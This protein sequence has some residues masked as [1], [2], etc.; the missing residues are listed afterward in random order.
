MIDIFNECAEAQSTISITKGNIVNIPL[1]ESSDIAGKYY[2]DSRDVMLA[3]ENTFSADP[4]L[5]LDSIAEHNNVP[6]SNIIV[7]MRESDSFMES[8]F[9]DSKIM[10]EASPE[11][12]AMSI[13]QAMAWYKK[14]LKRS[15]GAGTKEELKERISVLK[16]CV[17]DMEK[18][19]RTLKR[20]GGATYGNKKQ[21]VYM[22]K[23][24]IPFNSIYRLIRRQDI[25]AGIGMLVGGLTNVLLPGLG[26]AANVTVRMTQYRNMIQDNI[27]KTKDAIEYL[28]RQLKNQ[29]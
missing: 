21:T 20:E 10:M 11:D 5:T 23:A 12:N 9:R 2:I 4:V 26:M 3:M 25:Y 29:E 18:A 28:E 16:A 1:V 19:L 22:L 7:L 27:D 8:Y 17:E 6:V 15:K 13:N 14:V 24:L